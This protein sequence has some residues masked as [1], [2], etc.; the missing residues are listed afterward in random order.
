MKEKN[1][2]EENFFGYYL[3]LD[4]YDCD[5]KTVGSLEKCYY[6]LDNLNK[7][8]K[9]KK[10]SQPFLIHT[11][12]KKYPDKAGLSGWIP[13]FCSKNKTFSGASIH[14]LTPTNFIS[15]DIYSCKDFD[16]EKIKK[17][18]QQIFKPKNIEEKNIQRGEKYKD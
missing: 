14:T 3:M 15:I 17:F 1:Q 4:L 18:T 12:D 9:V 16:K 6:Y 7:V 5:V 10:L 13:F 8:M 2:K 11:D